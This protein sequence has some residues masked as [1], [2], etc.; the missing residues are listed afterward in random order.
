MKLKA[1]PRSGSVVVEV[2]TREAG[3]P[4]IALPELKLKKVLLPVDF[5][6][7]SQKALQYALSFARQFQ[8]EVLLLHVVETVYPPP[9]LVVLDSAALDHRVRDAAERQLA[10][11]SKEISGVR[12]RALI[13]SGVPHHEIVAAA[14]ENNIDLIILGTH[15]RSG[16]AHLFLG[17]TAER[18][19][20]RAPCP[21]MVVREREHD[22]VETPRV[23]R[24]GRSAGRR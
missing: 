17:S 12:A 20:R 1:A 3:L 19:V 6:E 2:G 16:M 13:R 14:E 8:A 23:T 21:V 7:C 22:F 18:V 9:E 5:S 4:P 24:S 11:W 15:G 10:A